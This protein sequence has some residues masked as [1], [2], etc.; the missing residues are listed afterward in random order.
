[1]PM[2]TCDQRKIFE[3]DFF[4]VESNTLIVRLW[5]LKWSLASDAAE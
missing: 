1:M 4:A 5:T 3:E 2:G